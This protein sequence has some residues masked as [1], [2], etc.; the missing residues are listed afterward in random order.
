MNQLLLLLLPPKHKPK[1]KRVKGLGYLCY[2][3]NSFKGSYIGDYTGEYYRGCLGN[4]RSVAYS[5]I[6]E[7][8]VEEKIQNEMDTEVC[9]GTFQ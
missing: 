6:M 3:L 1:A 7:K 4:T 5:S 8:Q 9:V 2:S